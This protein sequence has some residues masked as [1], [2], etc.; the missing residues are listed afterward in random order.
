MNKPYTLIIVDD[1]D[2]ACLDFRQTLDS[3]GYLTELVLHDQINVEQIAQIQPNIIF[4]HYSL[5]D[6][7][8]VE[9]IEAIRTDGR[10]NKIPVVGLV[11]HKEVANDLCSHV[12]TVL[13]RPVNIERLNKLLSLLNSNNHVVDKN[14]WD[15]LTGLV[16]SGIFRGA[17]AAYT[18]ALKEW[19]PEPVYGLLDQ[20][21]P[22][23]EL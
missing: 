19:L 23:D 2:I 4:A 13:L 15:A 12:D 16:Q 10:L 7:S 20:P 17:L 11:T 9:T 3:S 22:V 8:G 14:P 1:L 5:A 6:I 21:G 18:Q